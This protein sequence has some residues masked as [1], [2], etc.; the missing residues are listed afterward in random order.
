M[1]HDLMGLILAENSE[2]AMGE[3]TAVRPLAAVPFGGRYRMVDFMLSCMVN[4][5]IVNVGIITPYNFRSL[6]D[7]LGTGKDWDID[8]KGNGLFLLPSKEMSETGEVSGGIDILNGITYHLNK[9]KQEYVLVSSCNTICN[10]DFA[11]VFK[12][13]LDA[14]ADI[15]MIYTEVGELNSKDLSSRVLVDAD[16]TGRVRDIHVFPLQQKTN[17]VYMQMFIVKKDLLLELIGDAVAHNKHHI[18]KDIFLP[19]LERLK[20]YGYK[21]EGYNRHIDNVKAFFDANLELLDGDIRKELFGIAKDMPIYT[22]I[23]D[24]VS[25]K[26]SQTSEVSNSFI[27]DGCLIEGTVKNSILFRG[28]HIGKGATVENC[29]L[30]QK[31]EVMDNCM[32]ENVVFDKEVILR[33]GKKLVGQDTYPMVIGKNTII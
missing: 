11:E 7:H 27:A 3:L 18:S 2:A 15:T 25:T 8:R 17:N 24:S 13:H 1:K 21:F 19:N 12:N 5:A 30:M 28:V 14:E 33:S 22:K 10:I 20:I 9:C 26:Y 31:S 29:I 32:L 6:S 16:E 23:K 4:S